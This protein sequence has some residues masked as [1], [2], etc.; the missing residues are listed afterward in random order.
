MSRISDDHVRDGG[1]RAWFGAWSMLM[2]HVD[3][4]VVTYNGVEHVVNVERLEELVV[5]R[6]LCFVL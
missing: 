6:E 1:C 5:V 3:G 2:E 4:V